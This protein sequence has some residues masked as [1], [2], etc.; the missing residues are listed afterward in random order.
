MQ[1]RSFD[2]QTG[3]RGEDIIHGGH[4]IPQMVYFTKL[5]YVSKS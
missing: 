5:K 3:V 4:S 1:K 2:E